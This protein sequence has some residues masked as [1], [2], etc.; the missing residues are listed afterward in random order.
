[1]RSK[2]QRH[3]APVKGLSIPGPGLH[4]A[5]LCRKR[6]FHGDAGAEQVGSLCSRSFGPGHN[7]HPDFHFEW[8]FH[9]KLWVHVYRKLQITYLVS[10]NW[11]GEHG[12]FG[13]EAF[14]TFQSL[15]TGRR[16]LNK[17]ASNSS[18]QLAGQRAHT[19]H[20]ACRALFKVKKRCG[21]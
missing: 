2:S 9:R 19:R 6:G 18:L 20:A 8:L 1:M 12:T 4:L 11:E 3:H 5:L 13:P 7:L 10:S 15:E 16:V 17:A 21:G 14:R